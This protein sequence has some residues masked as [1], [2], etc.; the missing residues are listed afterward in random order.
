MFAPEDKPSAEGGR[1]EALQW[2]YARYEPM[3]SFPI[4]QFGPMQ[5]VKTAYEVAECLADYTAYLRAKIS[6]LQNDTVSKT[7][8][9]HTDIPL[10]PNPPALKQRLRD[11]EERVAELERITMTIRPI[12]GGL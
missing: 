2:L 10:P 3:V 8:D 5:A 12:G 11:L 9:S 6:E 7:N 1:A 4:E